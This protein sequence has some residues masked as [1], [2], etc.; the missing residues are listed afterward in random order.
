MYI[1]EGFEIRAGHNNIISLSSTKIDATDE[2]RNL[3]STQRNCL[4]PDEQAIMK[5]HNNYTYYNCM[6][7]CALF[8]A[9]D[10]T[11]NSCVPW[12]IPS[13]KESITICDP[14]QARN[15]F[16]YMV[17][18]IPGKEKWNFLILLYTNNF[19]GGIVAEWSRALIRSTPF[20]VDGPNKLCDMYTLV[21]SY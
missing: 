6:F 5:V 16:D 17:N 14:W 8:Y 15:F 4:F 1:Q 18:K 9:L 7:E 3:N 21:D 12:Y 2:L 19:L 10:K 11:N 20:R 13:P